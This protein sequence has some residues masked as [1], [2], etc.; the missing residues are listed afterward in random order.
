MALD[1]G[2][3]SKITRL[4]RE[5]KVQVTGDPGSV[6]VQIYL[7]GLVP[8]STGKS[9]LK[10]LIDDDGDFSSGTTAIIDPSMYDD[11]TQVV[12][13]NDIN[14]TNDQYFTVVTD[15][16]NQAPGG[17]VPNLYTWFRADK[18]VTIGTGVSLWA[19]QS[20]SLKDVTQ[21]TGTAQPVYNTT[22][23][24][25]NFNP[26]LNFD[27]STD[28]LSNSSISHS[29]TANGEEFFAVVL[30]N[31][32]AG[33]QDII[34]LGTLTNTNTATEFRYNANRIEYLANNGVAQSITNPTATN[35]TSTIG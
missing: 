29:A 11:A 12:T 14:F 3:C 18:G 24:L 20:A 6:Q 2:A 8:N 21:V 25:I 30:P 34:G 35:G 32:V 10:L 17:V 22:S 5:W 16:T 28:V 27:G 9:D 7:A 33:F 19:D 13:F 26:D 4:Q 31:T 23:N 1:P 15:L